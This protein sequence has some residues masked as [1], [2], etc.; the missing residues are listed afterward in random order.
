MSQIIIYINH[1][2]II[3][4]GSRCGIIKAR[5][6][7]LLAITLTPTLSRQLI[8]C[9]GNFVLAIFWSLSINIK[10]LFRVTT[11]ERVTWQLE[12]PSKLIAIISTIVNIFR[13]VNNSISRVATW[14]WKHELSQ[15]NARVKSRLDVQRWSLII[16]KICLACNAITIYCEKNRDVARTEFNKC[17]LLKLYC[18][19]K[20]RARRRISPNLPSKQ[21]H[22]LQLVGDP[23]LPKFM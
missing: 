9:S 5:L 15:C 1:K 16:V 13:R 17:L 22:L 19:T 20:H 7:C 3:K 4:F 23:F 21:P 11:H 6:S 18:N 10:N 2:T 14:N 12:N 8:F